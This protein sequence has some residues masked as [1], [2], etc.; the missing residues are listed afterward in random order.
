[1]RVDIKGVYAANNTDAW[2]EEEAD[3][4]ANAAASGGECAHDVGSARELAVV[5]SDYYWGIAPH[6]RI[7]LV[8]WIVRDDQYSGLLHWLLLIHHLWLLL[9]H[10]L[11]LLVHRLLLLVHRLL[12]LSFN[13]NNVRLVHK[14]LIFGHI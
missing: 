11:L 6:A 13:N 1:M 7:A 14:W 9:V 3:E 8:S 4:N 2:P 12:W 10:R 5:A